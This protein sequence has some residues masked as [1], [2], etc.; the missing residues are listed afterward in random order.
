MHW[1]RLG[2]AALLL[3]TGGC[4]YRH[5]FPYTH[6]FTASPV[7]EVRRVFTDSNG[8]FYPSR[9]DRAFTPPHK[10]WHA[11]SLLAESLDPAKPKP[12]LYA[13]IK[14]DEAR[15][16]DELE[17]FMAGRKR[18]FIL[19]HGINNDEE[20][21]RDAYRV[22]R[23]TIAP[24]AGD[25]I[26]E[27]YW[28]GLVTNPPKTSMSIAPARFWFDAAA[29][30]KVAGARGL[31]RILA[32]VKDKDVH[33]ISHSRG[34]AVVLAALADLPQDAGFMRGI[35]ALDF[36]PDDGVAGNPGFLNPP[37]L[38]DHRNRY[39]LIFMAGAIGCVDFRMPGYADLPDDG[40][41]PQECKNLRPVPP[42]LV[43]IR[44]TLNPGDPVLGKYF[45]PS[46][47]LNPT[48][49]GF[50]PALGLAL[51]QRW[52]LFPYCL[53]K[54]HPHPFARYVADPELAE[55]LQAAG[56]KTRTPR[57][58]TPPRSCEEPPA[59]DKSAKSQ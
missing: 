19:V 10:K 57:A 47:A 18:L 49:F 37:P 53:R 50:R 17:R 54:E 9:W 46:K 29:Y 38:P 36:D 25:G 1:V 55:M 56:V 4:A 8:T 7:A 41:A 32:R 58:P 35:E 11:G 59:Q 24:R 27:F 13:L 45:L 31:R 33:L 23:Q 16:L 2:F 26:V 40:L 6:S 44:Y 21:A 12:A 42:G 28:D 5:N 43:E 39:R 51:A 52:P 15:Q 34:A 3:L 22:I 14:S 20:E 48:D 30:S